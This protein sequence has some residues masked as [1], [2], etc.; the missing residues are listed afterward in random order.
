[1]PM[2]IRALVWTLAAAILPLGHLP[3]AAQA[4]PGVLAPP[5]ALLQAPPLA[6]TTDRRWEAAFERER[7]GAQVTRA[8]WVYPVVGAVAG[9]ALGIIWGKDVDRRTDPWVPYGPEA[10]FGA[11]GAAG[12]AL[13]GWYADETDRLW[14]RQRRERER[15]RTATPAT[16]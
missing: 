14:D 6:P 10:F 11:L 8:R 7:G 1:M 4:D 2:P 12:G 9:G 13:V 3:L 5:S 16:P 15:E